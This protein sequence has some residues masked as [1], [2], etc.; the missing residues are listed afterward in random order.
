MLVNRVNSPFGIAQAAQL[1]SLTTSL[2]VVIVE[3]G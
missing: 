1:Y 2:F 3:I